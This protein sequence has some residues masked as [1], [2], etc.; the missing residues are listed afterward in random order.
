MKSNILQQFQCVYN[1]K[2]KPMI[3]FKRKGMPKEKFPR[4]VL[5][6]HPKAE[7][8]INTGLGE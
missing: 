6:V 2:L 8:D 5:E 3:M 4:G 1:T 7:R